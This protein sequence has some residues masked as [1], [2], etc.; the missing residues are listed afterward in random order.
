MSTQTLHPELQREINELEIELIV[1]SLLNLTIQPTIFYGMK[2]AQVLDPELVHIMERICEGKE[3]TF[4]L[5]ED[6]I[7]H[8]EGRLCVTNDVDIC[9]QILSEAHEAL[10]YSPAW[11]D[12][13]VPMSKRTFLV[14]W[15]GKGCG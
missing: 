2:G 14:E 9:K 5:S 11:G 1:E 15:N 3:T 7:L 13:D 4:T 8:L 12:K 10:Y 6:G